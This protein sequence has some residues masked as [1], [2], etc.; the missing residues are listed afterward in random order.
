MQS[1]LSDIGLALLVALGMAWKTGWTLVLGFS[2][3]SILQAIVSTKSVSERLGKGTAKELAFA[4]AAGAASSSCSYASAAIMRTLYKKGA[5]LTNAL[6][7]LFASTNLV[8]ELGI[9]LF[10][11]LGWQFMAAEWIGGILLI[12]IMSVVVKLTYPQKL[13]EK[14]RQHEE[15]EGG[16]QHSA[17]PLSGD[18]W[19]QRLKDPEAP[20]RISQNFLMEWSMLWKDLMIGFLIGGF[21]SVF[22]PD[23]FW[24]AIFFSNTSEWIKLPLNAIIG[25]L[26]A[27]V[28]F[29]C[30]IGNVPLAAVL[31]A[32]GASFGGVLSFIYADLIILPLLDAYRRYFGWKMAAYIGAV[33]FATMVIAGIVMDV[34]FTTLGLVPSEAPDIQ[35]ELTS[36]AVDYTFWLN[37]IFALPAGWMVWTG[38]HNKSQH[39]HH[40]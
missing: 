36:F 10:L 19:R 15:T 31:F 20:V 9:I 24:Q 27:I 30:S 13:A 32:S 35:R 17:E 8:I 28:T 12:A 38:I 2:I 34:I 33:L 3:S 23:S 7:F 18:T 4:T 5:A 21:L 40:G 14:A 29:V 39:H 1:F 16:H 6:A 37:L 22:I 11:L 25:P 26:I